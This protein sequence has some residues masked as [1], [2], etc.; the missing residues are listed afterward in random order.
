MSKAILIN[1]LA[2]GGAE[3][4]A[5]NLFRALNFDYLIVFDDSDIAYDVPREKIICLGA[6]PSKGLRTKFLNLIRRVYLTKKIK[7]EKNIDVCISFLEPANLINVLS[8]GKELCI[9]SFRVNYTETLKND[10]FLGKGLLR[11]ITVFLYKI[12][13]KHIY[14]RA[15]FMVTISNNARGDLIENFGL[16]ERKTV[17]IYN[18]FYFENIQKLSKERLNNDEIVFENRDTIATVGRLTKQKGQWY[19]L[20]IYRELKRKFPELKLLLL[21]D[22]E[23]KEYLVKLSEDLN[24]KTYVW[25]R[26]DLSGDFDVYFLG[27][28]KNPFKYISRSKVFVFP[29]LW[30][31]FPNALVEAMACGI[32][33]VSADCRSGPREILSPDTDFNYQTKE[34][35]F[36]EYGVLM[37]PFDVE[38]KKAN[39]PL[40]ER[41][42]VW[43]EVLGELLQD[44]ELRRKYSR[45]ALERARDFDVKNIVK[46]WEGI[47]M[48]RENR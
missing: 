46:D 2:K 26:D 19:L 33:V 30:E 24:L 40:G 25:D 17:T 21:G 38:F 44:E 36:A 5:V 35:E 27:F 45:K 14:N 13:F 6:P 7:K 23:L 3:R 15:N 11:K 41:E 8:K 39:E 43:V 20:R 29:S 10:P 42:K 22:G 37:P 47:L 31:G 4:V 28:R 16:D 34:P 48:C 12:M 18:P 1:S 32:P 9:T